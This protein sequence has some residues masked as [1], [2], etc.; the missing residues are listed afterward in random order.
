M[1]NDI[2]ILVKEHQKIWKLFK[3]MK[4]K[5]SL[6][7]KVISEWKENMDESPPPELEESIILSEKV[8]NLFEDFKIKHQKIANLLNNDYILFDKYILLND[9][10]LDENYQKAD[11]I[12]KEI[13]NYNN[14]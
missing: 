14:Y 3:E 10:L 7:D 1:N 9:Y 13:N 5:I 4:N 6:N 12:L 8:I 2:L 11:D